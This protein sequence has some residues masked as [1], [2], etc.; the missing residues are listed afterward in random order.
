MAIN[1]R[2][3]NEMKTR[4]WIIV[5][6][7]AL[8]SGSSFGQG[9][10]GFANRAAIIAFVEITAASDEYQ[11]S[12]ADKCGIFYNG[13][14][15]DEIYGAEDGSWLKF[16]S[17][18]SLMIGGTYLVFITEDIDYEE[19]L[20][21]GPL[22]IRA[23]TCAD[24]AGARTVMKVAHAPMPDF[25]PEAIFEVRVTKNDNEHF[26]VGDEFV[27]ANKEFGNLLAQVAS[28]DRDEFVVAPV[29]IDMPRYVV[30][31]VAI[32]KRALTELLLGVRTR[33]Q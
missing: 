7:I 26:E 29:S 6:M 21:S 16:R 25:G 32:D 23:K 22:G 27:F 11:R 18:S 30:E 19:R 15:T 24:A 2:Q 1:S 12:V 10:N 14:V 5:S 28:Q 4:D 9:I 13:F 33:T 17:H 8:W 3:P 31:G 20:G